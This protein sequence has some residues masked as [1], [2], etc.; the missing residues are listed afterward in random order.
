MAV[1]VNGCL[2]LG[3][4]LLALLSG[5]I[6]LL[7]EAV[8]SL[9]DIGTSGVVLWAT[10]LESRAPQDQEDAKGFGKQNL[11]RK[12]AFFIGLF[13]LVLSISIFLKVFT[14]Q[15]IRV[16]YPAL[17]AAG[18]VLAA[19]LSLVLARLE[20]TTGEKERA[21]ALLAD[22]HHAKVDMYGSFLVALAL[23]GEGLELN[24]DRP[25]AAIISVFVFAQAC[26]VFR[27]IF[28]EPSEGQK[29]RRPESL[30]AVTKEEGVE[31]LTRE[32]G[33]TRRVL[34]VSGLG[35]LRGRDWR[36][37][38]PRWRLRGILFLVLL[39]VCSGI[40]AVQPYQKAFVERFGKPRVEQGTV[41]PGLHYHLPWP[42]ERVRLVDAMRVR[43]LVIGSEVSPETDMALWTNKH[44]IKEFNLLT[45]ENIFV[46]T[47][48]V[49]NYRISSVFDFL[50][51][52]TT[53]ETLLEKIGYSVL[54]REMA[55][56]RFFNMVTTG[57]DTLEQRLTEG[58]QKAAGRL[59]MG[60]RVLS[61]DLRDIHPPT[62]VAKHFE[63]V[64]G[65]A[66]DYETF[67]NEAKGYRNGLLPEANA[68]GSA[69]KGE[70]AARSRELVLK[71]QGE[72]RRFLSHLKEYK[73]A[74]AFHRYRYL[75][76]AAETCLPR[77]EKVLVPG[78]CGG[79]AV[80]LF[81]FE[82]VP[83]KTA[84]VQG[85]VPEKED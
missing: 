78:P 24:L 80:D 51:Q 50:Y 39:Y 20:R 30:G 42:V 6:A 74:P 13:L 38:L 83:G 21:M 22:S 29:Q 46:D 58:I 63:E 18:M 55:G 19:M 45:G 69:M 32:K 12:V 4:F 31:T 10:R 48:A 26:Q 14:S 75:M 47:S 79:A 23:L 59:K 84:V 65:A 35:M 70:A 68:E 40:Y 66:V 54:L 5:S 1:G 56:S 2:S 43:R 82:E 81:V 62:R 17:T 71:S 57:R 36:G 25:A 44:Y 15:P 8:H 61:V 53:P 49:V 52:S 3:K 64:V 77:A 60:L 76:E 7:A 72:S 67:I 28:G 16:K 85:S 27:G 11:Q 34:Y 41:G 37:K 9:T 73:R 33:K